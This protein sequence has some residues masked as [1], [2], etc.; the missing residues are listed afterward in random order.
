MG[1]HL[2]ETHMVNLLQVCLSFAR[3]RVQGEREA[4]RFKHSAIQHPE[5]SFWTID[6]VTCWW[7][8]KKGV[9]WPTAI[10]IDH[11]FFPQLLLTLPKTLQITQDFQVQVPKNGG[12][13]PYSRLFW[14]RVFPLHKALHP[15][16]LY[17]FSYLHFRYPK[18]LVTNF[19]AT[20]WFFKDIASENP[21]GDISSTSQLTRELGSEL[22]S[23]RGT[24]KT[25]L[26]LNQIDVW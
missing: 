19:G 8:Q 16:N 5:I 13:E 3:V 10:S 14:G 23:T 24:R 12:T 7:V 25:T 26:S 6:V 2:L 22:F 11:G 20:S 1:H 21:G 4:C 9:S 18:C 17:R 15:Y